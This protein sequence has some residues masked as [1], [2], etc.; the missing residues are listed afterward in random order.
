MASVVVTCSAG[1][2]Q[3]SSGMVMP[4]AASR[5][6]T[7]G[8]LAICANTRAFT[9]PLAPPQAPQTLGQVPG[10]APEPSQVSQ[11]MAAGTTISTSAPAKACSR[12]ISRS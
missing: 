10:L 5:S 8:L 11:V 12:V 6:R 1:M 2:N 9:M 4:M 7:A 3:V